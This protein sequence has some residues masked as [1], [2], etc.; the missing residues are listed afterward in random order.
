MLRLA[1]IPAISLALGGCALSEPDGAYK[2]EEVIADISSSESKLHGTTV[3]VHGWLGD[4][5]SGLSC[6]I[7]DNLE[8][9]EKVAAYQTLPDD[10]WMPAMDRGLSIGG[11]NESFDFG[12]MFMQFDRVVVVG[13]INGAYHQPPDENGNQW[14]CW[15]RCDHIKPKSIKK[16]LF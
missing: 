10:E 5:S 4:C 14:G 2:V 15:D 1:A 3:S 12:A 11:G 7:F 8:D 13:E 16:I 6:H 9:A